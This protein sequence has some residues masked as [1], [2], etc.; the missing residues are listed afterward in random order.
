M[1]EPGTTAGAFAAHKAFLYSL[2]V[3]GFVLTFWLGL[4]YAP[5][6]KEAQWKDLV[7]RL[8]ACVVSSFVC[9]VPAVLALMHYYPEAFALASQLALAMG[10]P[11]NLGAV[12][13]IVIVCAWILPLCSLPGPWLFAA[14]YL[15]LKRQKG[16][17]AGEIIKTVRGK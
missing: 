14:V 12:A 4:R 2:P 16:K 9:G 17:D 3:I 5:L 13:G 8:A 11:T 10:V 7:D 6:R 15:W 1:T